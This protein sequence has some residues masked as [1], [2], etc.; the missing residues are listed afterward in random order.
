VPATFVQEAGNVFASAVTQWTVTFGSAVTAG[1]VVVIMGRMGTANRTMGT[2]AGGS[3]SS[4]TF[5]SVQSI[6][7]NAVGALAMW[8]MVEAGTGVTSYTITISG[9]LSAAGVIRAWEISGANGATADSSG[10]GTQTSTTSPQMVDTGLTIPSGGIMIGAFSTQGSLSWTSVTTAPANFTQS[11]TSTTAPG[12][13]MWTGY[14]TT[15]ASGVTG[16]A[17]VTTARAIWGLGAVWAEAAAAGG[18]P[19]A[20]RWGGIPNNAIRARRVW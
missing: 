15:A 9:G 3:G 11:Y 2:P 19:F 16:S 4:G 20:K 10:T 14:N 1:N 13:S 12:A 7:G 5:A 17:T 8:S 18:Q 6:G